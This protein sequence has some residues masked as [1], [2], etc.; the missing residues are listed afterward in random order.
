MTRNS[1][2]ILFCLELRPSAYQ[3]NYVDKQGRYV[4]LCENMN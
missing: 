2:H 4:T 3:S 1:L